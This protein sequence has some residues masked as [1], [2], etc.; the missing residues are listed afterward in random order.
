VSLSRLIT[1]ERARF[2]RFCVVGAS[3]VVVNLAV[4]SLFFEVVLTSQFGD[5]D[6][7]IAVANTIGIIISIFTNFLLNNHWTWGDRVQS[8]GPRFLSKGFGKRLG[9]FYLVS[10]IAGAVQLGVTQIVHTNF[11]VMAQMAV[12]A[13]IAVA[14]A[15]N[16][17]ANNVWT[18]RSELPDSP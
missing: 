4:F 12:L 7:R 6:T 5:I 8:D 18:F 1:P 10:S 2:I 9:K 14:T 3:G 17:V 11:D 16:F 15:I 13:G